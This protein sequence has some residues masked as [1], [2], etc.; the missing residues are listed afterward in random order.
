MEHRGV[1]TPLYS[2]LQEVREGSMG[3]ECWKRLTG[4]VETRQRLKKVCIAK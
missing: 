4:D 1:Y 2:Q 3:R